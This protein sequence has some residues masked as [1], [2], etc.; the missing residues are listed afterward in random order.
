MQPP[1][2]PVPETIDPKW[3]LKAVAAVLAL[4]LCCAYL[5]VSGLFWYGQ[6]QLVLHPARMP[7]KQPA[8][9][10]LQ[11]TAVQFGEG[12]KGWWIAAD[13]ANAPVALMLPSGDGNAGD[14]LTRARSLHDAGLAV[15]LFDYR[16][17]GGSSGRHPAQK[18]MRVDSEDALSY[19]SAHAQGSRIL[20]YGTGA[21]ASLATR[22]CAEHPEIEA[23]VLENADGD[24]RERARRDARA[25]IAPFSM[26]FH[27]DFP[28][29][30][31][32]SQLK[33][34][35]LIVSSTTHGA[36]EVAH[37][38]ADP[39]FVAEIPETANDRAFRDTLK[40]FL[41]MYVPHGSPNLP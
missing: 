4:G 15:L 29:A 5:A 37:R 22:L 20:A 39:K 3:L 2:K 7:E 19:V 24:F 8:D 1:V 33:T 18:T 10:H 35:K 23:L 38:A 34:P 26:L 14:S 32:L 13:S 41:D 6:W 30:D 36:P 17:Y 27:E 11:A 9:E 12:L 40:R 21:G 31:P 28:L 25:S 16:G